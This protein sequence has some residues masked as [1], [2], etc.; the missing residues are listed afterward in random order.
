MCINKFL[1][2]GIHVGSRK[3]NNPVLIKT[4]EKRKEICSPAHVTVA[5]F[6][7]HTDRKYG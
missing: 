2:M 5:F 4:K 1:D 3:Q 7:G 6:K